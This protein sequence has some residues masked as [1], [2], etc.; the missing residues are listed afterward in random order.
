GDLYYAAPLYLNVLLAGKEKPEPVEQQLFVGELPLMT[1]WGTFIVNGTERVVV[2][3]LLRSP[4]VYFA[5]EED[6]ATGR[7]LGKAKLIPDRG[8]WL[9]LETSSR[10]V[11]YV[12]LDNK[13]RVAITALF[14]ALG[15]DKEQILNLFKK[16]DGAAEHAY[17]TTTM[18]AADA[19]YAKAFKES[20]GITDQE[21]ALKYLY[22]KLRPGDPMSLENARALVD[23]L[24]HN[25]R[26]YDLGKMGRYR[27]NRRLGF[28]EAYTRDIIKLMGKLPQLSAQ[29]RE[30]I[31]RHAQRN[32]DEVMMP[33]KELQQQLSQIKRESK[34]NVELKTSL[35]QVISRLED[36][37]LTAEDMVEIMRRLLLLNNG[38]ETTD[39]IDHL[40][41][42]R[43][44]TVGE[45]LLNQFRLGFLRLERVIRDRM[46]IFDPKI[47]TP[48]ALINIRP[49]QG[50]IREFFAGSQLS[51]FMD[52]T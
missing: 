45:L 32:S 36:Q 21:K 29:L 10:D 37:A 49:I 19:D 22:S 3:Q 25:P 13:R 44:R 39:D 50:V 31:V 11:I 4:G 35:A 24:F 46:S 5:V 6:T 12:K 8:G 51:Q 34:V 7:L 42:R 26:R 33:L 23:N 48:V 38:R 40:G 15:Y 20:S 28:Y 47:A 43:V 52:Q 1:P 2:S 18:N 9:E 41:N 30:A 17:I 27:L 14:Q 16:E